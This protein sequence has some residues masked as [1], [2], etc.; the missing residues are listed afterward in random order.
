MT[1]DQEPDI[2]SDQWEKYQE[3]RAE[4]FKWACHTE[5]PSFD[6]NGRNKATM[7]EVFLYANGCSKKLDSSKGLWIHGPVGTGKST[8]IRILR[9]YDYQ[10]HYNKA[11]WKSTGGFGIVS[12]SLVSNQFARNG[13]EGIDKYTYNNNEPKTYA[14]DEVGREP[15]PT[16]YYGT[17]M[18]VMQFIF[19]TR[20]ELRHRCITHVTTNMDPENI[21]NRYDD[22]IADRVNEMFNVIKLDGESRR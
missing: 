17:E 5:C 1:S 19:Q 14:F 11:D 12:A 9:T 16:K 4:V 22:Y 15:L 13:L 2:S 3:W 20:Y 8:I 10:V 18:N 21:V 7:N 6:I